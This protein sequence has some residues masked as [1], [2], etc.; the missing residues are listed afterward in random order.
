MY[1]YLR[2][3]IFMRVLELLKYSESSIL[4]LLEC[5]LA[6]PSLAR[7]SASCELELGR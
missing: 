2:I 4:A 5:S 7:G 6:E 1:I 3:L